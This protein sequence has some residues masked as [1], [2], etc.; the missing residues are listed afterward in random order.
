MRFLRGALAAAEL[1]FEG[2]ADSGED[3]SGRVGSGAD[4]GAPDTDLFAVVA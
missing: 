3:D 1:A 4:R 2:V